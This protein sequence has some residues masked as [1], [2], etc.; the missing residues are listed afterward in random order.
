MKIGELPLICFS[1]LS[2]QG[3]RVTKGSIKKSIPWFNDDFGEDFVFE[4]VVEALTFYKDTFGSF[5]GLDAEFVVPEP[6][7]GGE[8]DVSAS[9]DAAAAIA[10]AE[11]MGEDSDALIAAEIERMELE[12]QG[13]LGDSSDSEDTKWPEHLAGMKLGSITKRIRDGSLEVKHLPERKKMLDSIDFDW[14]DERSFLDIPFEKTMCAMFAYFLV[15]GDLFVYEDFVMPGD[16]PWPAALAGFELG[17]AVKRFREL[18]NFFE[19][20]HPE[21]VKLLRRVEF[22]WFPELALPLNPEEGLE[23][24]EDTYVEGMGHP[25]YQLN[26]PS[27]GT[28]ER[29]VATG[30]NGNE[31]LTSSYY[32]YNEV[33]DFW[34]KGDVTSAGKES[35]RPGWKPAEW[36]WFNG[37]EQLSSEHE[38]R[39][40][41]SAG[42]EMIRLINSF[43]DGEISE[44]EFDKQAQAA[45][46]LWEEEQL[47]EE[48]VS[49]GF[50]VT[51]ADDMTAIIDKIKN[52]PECQAIDED[53][54]YKK[55]IEAEI[56]AEQAR[57]AMIQKIEMEEM[58]IEPQVEEE[59][60]ED[61]EDDYEYEYEYED[62][63]EAEVEVDEEED[64]D[65]EFE[66]DDDDDE[67]FVEEEEAAVDDDFGIE[68]DL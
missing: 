38:Q 25:F 32:D 2:R 14:G 68:E 17:K 27:V 7:F 45:I 60:L 50:D 31:D 52:D 41:T 49:A 29:L 59:S 5:D 66:D 26:E 55:M 12:M 33:S 63:E 18:Q 44:D 8:F 46:L 9:A 42:L 24:W 48:A 39:Y 51:R 61:D 35:E 34:E 58:E 16:K 43:Q 20:Y 30:P 21:K 56:D 54:E 57:A 67:D 3:K 40:G 10:K 37:F 11:S 64:D 47:R 53:P 1:V 15:R 4:D 19:A 23:S 22:V 28:I 65:V 62:D 13:E 6:S 36:L